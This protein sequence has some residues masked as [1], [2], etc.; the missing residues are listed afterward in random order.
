[1]KEKIYGLRF[2]TSFKNVFSDKNYLKQFFKDI[3]HEEIENVTYIDKEILRENKYL[4]YSIFDLLIKAKGEFI[5]FEMQNQDLKNIEAR[6]TMYLSKYY[7][8]QNAGKK[9]EHVKPIKMRLILNYPYGEKEVLK[10]YRVMEKRILEQFGIY[11]DIKIWN[12]KEALK[13]EGTLDYK[14]ALLFILD[15]FSKKKAREVLKTIKEEKRFEEMIYKIERYNANLETYEKLKNEE[16]RQM[17]L[18]DVAQAYKKEGIEI[19]KKQGEKRG[20][21]RGIMK[22]ALSMLQ[23]GLDLS[24]IKKITGL[25]ETEILRIDKNIDSL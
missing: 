19:G 11:F 18:E 3:F 14:Y 24:L 6:V 15:L 23:E 17:K 21:K 1:M 4:S 25:T 22:T 13:Y 5:I 12:I 16:E 7:A 10:E 8:R 9:Y 2:D 20:E